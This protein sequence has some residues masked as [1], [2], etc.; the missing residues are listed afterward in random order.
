MQKLDMYVNTVTIIIAHQLQQMKFCL[1]SC[2]KK[3]EKAENKFLKNGQT[4][5][6]LSSYR[7]L[8]VKK[9]VHTQPIMK[10]MVKPMVGI[11]RIPFMDFV[12][13]VQE[14]VIVQFQA[15]KKL[16]N[17][18]LFFLKKSNLALTHEV[19]YSS[20]VSFVA[21]AQSKSFPHPLACTS[22]FA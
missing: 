21:S 1:N 7:V 10:L 20:F 16:N 19:A 6:R 13:L 3:Q 5:K 2:W 18:M 9:H 12:V 22:C 8:N 14:T 17:E 15:A 11:I 4:N